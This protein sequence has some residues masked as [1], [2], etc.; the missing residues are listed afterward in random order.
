MVSLKAV[1]VI[2][3]CLVCEIPEAILLFI[4]IQLEAFAV[5][6]SIKLSLGDELC[7]GKAKIKHIWDFTLSPSP[8]F[9]LLMGTEQVPQTVVFS[10]TMAC[11]PTPKI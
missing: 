9:I 1:S 10:V 6:R 11:L 5:N 3:S 7:H 8:L 4:N 2:N